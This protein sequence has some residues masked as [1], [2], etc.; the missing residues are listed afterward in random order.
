MTPWSIPNTC[1]SPVR[2]SF[3]LF[4]WKSYLCRDRPESTL[5]QNRLVRSTVP[6]EESRQCETTGCSQQDC[7]WIRRIDSRKTKNIPL[8]TLND[9]Q[10]TLRNHLICRHHRT[11]Q[12]IPPCETAG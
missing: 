2:S 11:S 1:F 4:P 7:N 3:S 12:G 6:R 10:N 5:Q 9:R 8:N